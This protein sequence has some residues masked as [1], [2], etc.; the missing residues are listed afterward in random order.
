MLL[1]L[2]HNGLSQD[3]VQQCYDMYQTD[4]ASCTELPP[5]QKQ[6]CI[7]EAGADLALCVSLCNGDEKNDESKSKQFKLMYINKYGYLFI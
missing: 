7:N 2:V 1:Q 6:M 5:A 3:C 4:L